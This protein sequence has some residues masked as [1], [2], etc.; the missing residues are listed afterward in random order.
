MYSNNFVYC[1]ATVQL[2]MFWTDLDLHQAKLRLCTTK[3]K[4]ELLTASVVRMIEQILTMNNFKFN[5]EYYLQIQGMA[6]GTRMAPSY[7]NIFKGKLE[8]QLLQYTTDRPSTWWWYIDDIFAIWSAGQERLQLF[9]QEINNF[10]PTIKFTSE[11][12]KECISSLDT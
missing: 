3:D 2:A 6:M 1:T 10:H 12:S 4:T 7:A 11:W 9:L 8:T 5:G